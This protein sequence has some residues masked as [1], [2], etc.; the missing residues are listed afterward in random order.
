MKVTNIVLSILILLLSVAAA[1]FS[2]FLFEK[3]SQFVTGWGKMAQTI[4]TSA[5]E[6]DKGSGTRSASELTFAA[7]SHENYANLDSL[8]PK[9]PAQS[10]K[11][12]NER[13]N[14]ARAL[15]AINGVIRNSTPVDEA[16]LC[17]VDSHTQKSNIVVSGVRTVVSN[18]DK[19]YSA[20]IRMASNDFKIT[21]RNNDLLQGKSD[22]FKPMSDKLR[23]IEARMRAYDGFVAALSRTFGAKYNAAD[24]EGNI[25][26]VNAAIAQYRKKFSDKERENRTL[27][28]AKKNLEARV[29]NLNAV[30][31]RQKAQIADRDAQIASF[32]RAFGLAESNSTAQWTDGS[33][34]ARK[35]FSAKVV[36]VNNKFGYI[37]INAGKY[38]VVQ[39]QIGNR[40]L[41][42]NPKIEAGLYM[43][44]TRPNG[45]NVDFIA[46][47]QLSQVGDNTSIAN[48]PPVSK[49][50]RVGDIVTLVVEDEKPADK[51]A[52]KAAK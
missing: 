21:I 44:V 27:A 36:S 2:Y 11:I 46:R 18:R 50:I 10:K 24:A 4:N 15:A 34:A 31:A 35:A 6:L 19:N 38:S 47:V 20:L 41:E 17:N 14:L 3:R 13:N 5:A 23:A 32:Q 1:V 8:L 39:Q 25:K 9:L 22:V 45:K 30:I 52:K 26:N 51:A 29:N 40:S 12:I 43:L 16:G 48:I 49:E 42:I 7:L 33:A 28:A 37:A